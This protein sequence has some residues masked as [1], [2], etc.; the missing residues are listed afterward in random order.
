MEKKIK[1]QLDNICRYC[2][3]AHTLQD[4]DTMLCD[5]KGLVNAGYH[6]RNFR[7]DPLKRV[8]GKARTVPALEFIPLDELKDQEEKQ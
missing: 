2:E 3:M 1:E 4:S 6:C 5:K 7:Y 8:P